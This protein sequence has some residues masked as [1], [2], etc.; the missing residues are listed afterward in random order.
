MA[1][2][3]EVSNCLGEFRQGAR[4]LPRC[5]WF[6]HPTEDNHVIAKAPLVITSAKLLRN[7]A[8]RWQIEKKG[9]VEE[10]FLFETILPG[11][12][13]PFAVL[14]NEMVF[15]PLSKVEGRT[16]L[17]KSGELTKQGRLY[18]AKWTKDNE[19]AWRKGREDPTK[20]LLD[21]LDSDKA[22]SIQNPERR[23]IVLYRP[24]PRS[25]ASLYVPKNQV[26]GCNTNGFVADH[27]TYYYYAKAEEEADYLSSILNCPENDGETRIPSFNAANPEHVALAQLGKECRFA[28]Q[29]CLQN[30]KDTRN[31]RSAI[32]RITKSKLSEIASIVRSSILLSRSTEK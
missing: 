11:C 17:M 6:V 23:L 31:I 32:R 26:Q 25:A 16:S 29:K 22:L 8:S 24:G 12:I 10:E 3:T 14:G 28:V 19:Q 20:T 9:R 2:K 21:E 13:L 1:T 7:S 5:F 30:I 27:E 18:A 15:L 4:L